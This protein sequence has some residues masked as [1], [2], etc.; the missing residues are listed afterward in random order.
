MEPKLI[1]SQQ[2]KSKLVNSTVKRLSVGKSCKDPAIAATLKHMG[3]IMR[4]SID[5]G[6]VVCYR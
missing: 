3:R 1:L 5:I 4:V 2:S 6:G